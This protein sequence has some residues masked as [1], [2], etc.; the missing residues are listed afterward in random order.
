MK[1]RLLDS[2]TKRISIA[3]A[4]LTGLVVLAAAAYI[5]L[6]SSPSQPANG[7]KIISA[8]H[9]YTQALQQHHAPVPQSIPLQ[10]LIDQGLLQPA[11]V[12]SFQG[13]DAKIFLTAS[14]S[15]PNI[16]MRVHLPD[17]TDLVLF[18]DGNAQQVKR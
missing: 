3:V 15:G 1:T 5:F 6:G 7:A 13:M 14:G 8:A 11:D 17:G 18:G 12:G 2:P 9:A 10:V 4:V 16:L